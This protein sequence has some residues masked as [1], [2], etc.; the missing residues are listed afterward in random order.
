MSEEGLSL[1]SCPC[2]IQ[3]YIDHNGKFC[4]V[5]VI[6]KEVMV[7]HRRS[8]P[9]L[10]PSKA[11]SHSA[12]GEPGMLEVVHSS[13]AKALAPQS[14]SVAFDSRY[15]YPTVEDFYENGQSSTTTESIPEGKCSQPVLEDK[16]NNSGRNI[17]DSSECLESENEFHVTTCSELIPLRAK[18]SEAARI[19]SDGF[20]LTL[21]GFDVIIPATELH[22]RN[23]LSRSGEE[24]VVI[25]VNFFP[26][27]K[28]IPDFPEKLCSYM[29]KRAGVHVSSRI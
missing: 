2:V 20:S 5:Y 28:E 17:I 23:I 29:I 8:L 16:L 25:D 13:P 27:Y 19:I 7:F 12:R 22:D 6:D 10:T 9:N 4:K 24:L 26:S 1:V 15:E 18:F 3:E 14:K 21:F 11:Q